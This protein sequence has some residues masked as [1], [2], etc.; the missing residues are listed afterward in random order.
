MTDLGTLGG[1]YGGAQAINNRGQI[2][3]QSSI[4]AD[5]GACN[6]FPDNGNLN[7]HAFLWDHGR[8]IDLTTSTIGGN[9]AFLAAINDAGEIIGWG[10]LRSSPLEAFLWRKGVATDLGHLGDCFSFT[11]S[12][13]SES[14]VVGATISCDGTVL[15]AFLWESGSMVDL[16]TLIPAGSS[17]QLID[18]TNINDRGEIVGDGVPSGA[19]GGK[20]QRCGVPADSM[21][22]K[23]SRHRR[24][25]LRLGGRRRHND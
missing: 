13:N 1:A 24:M 5:P 7:C 12:I 20:L 18:A 10:V 17:L 16:N 23:P 9:P 15:R 22:R 4:A 8:L 2:I 21:R 3:G 11:H 6:G 19:A 25:R 14:Q